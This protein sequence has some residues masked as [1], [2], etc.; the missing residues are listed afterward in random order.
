MRFIFNFIFFG[1][2]FYAIWIFFPETFQ[3]LVG[4]I[5][6]VYDFFRDLFMR[7]AEQFGYGAKKPPE[8]SEPATAA[9]LPFL[10]LSRNFFSRWF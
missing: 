4:W 2:L 7:L 9:F 6:K 8:P 5:A 1:L 10:W 3:T